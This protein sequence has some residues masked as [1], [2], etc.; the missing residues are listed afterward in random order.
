MSKQLIPKQL[1]PKQLMTSSDIERMGEVII[2]HETSNLKMRAVGWKKN[3]WW[4][5]HSLEGGLPTVGYGHKVT[6]LES[7]SGKFL[8][9]ITDEEAKTLLYSDMRKHIWSAG[10]PNDWGYNRTL[11]ALDV[12]YRVGGSLKMRTPSFFKALS[13]EDYSEAFCQTADLY[14]MT[15]AGRKQY[16]DNRNIS[17]ARF[18]GLEPSEDD[19]EKYRSIQGT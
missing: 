12:S 15:R 10:I 14:Y 1:I 2:L 6:N 11:W 9:G 16:Y 13:E 3:K 7:I 5:Y 8:S 17:L 19:M 4:P 18:C